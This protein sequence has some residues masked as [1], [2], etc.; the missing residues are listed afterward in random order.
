MSGSPN[1]L[2]FET[3]DDVFQPATQEHAKSKDQDEDKMADYLEARQR[4]TSTEP[5]D[6][7]WLSDLASHR[8]PRITKQNQ[9]VQHFEFTGPFVLVVHDCHK[10]DAKN[11]VAPSH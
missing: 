10:P 6:G 1:P 4:S 9:N 3:L 7:Q 2:C 11:C 5:R 8:E